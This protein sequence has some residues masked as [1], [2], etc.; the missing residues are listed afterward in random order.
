MRRAALLLLL[1]LALLDCKKKP[2]PDEAPAP[3]PSA[4]PPPSAPEEI[5]DALNPPPPPTPPDLARG[6]TLSGEAQGPKQADLDAV[7]KQGQDKVQSCLDSLPSTA[8][9]GGRASL[10][11]RY[12][13]G[14]DGK[15]S[16]V[17]VEGGSSQAQSCARGVFESLQFPTFGGPV[18]GSTFSLNYS[19]PGEAQTPPDLSPP[20]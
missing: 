4:P 17:V 19:R 18:V 10:Q 5:F 2:L 11:I 16:Q 14:N 20:R 13:I 12:V 15:T 6:G 7:R 9:G 1:P 3:S 8:L